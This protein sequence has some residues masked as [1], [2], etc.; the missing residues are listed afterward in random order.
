MTNLPSITEINSAVLPLSYLPPIDQYCYIARLGNISFEIYET[1]PKQTCRN[2]TTILTANGLL[3]LTIPVIKTYGNRT[4]TLEVK[5]DNSTKWNRIH[6]KA[7]NSAYNKS[8]FFLYYKDEIELL[9]NEPDE[10]LMDFNIRL[11]AQINKLLKLKP[12]INYTTEF[13]KEYKSIPDLRNCSKSLNYFDHHLVNYTQ[14]FSDRYSFEP[15][16]S[17]LDLLF[18]EGPNALMYLRNAQI[19]VD[20]V[21]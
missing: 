19:K 18:N 2:R 21:V 9:Y 15:N 12:V 7:I 3:R 13:L 5:I 6:W 8:P 16:L 11:I 20:Q 1:Y 10:L 14:V 17:I 4:K